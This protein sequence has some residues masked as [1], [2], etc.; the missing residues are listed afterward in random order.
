MD[1]TIFPEGETLVVSPEALRGGKSEVTEITN[2]NHHHHFQQ[3][4]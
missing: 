1:G 3:Q 4:Q 2:L